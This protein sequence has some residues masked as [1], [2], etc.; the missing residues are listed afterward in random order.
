M[1][2]TKLR[3]LAPPTLNH[4][5][6]LAPVDEAIEWL[7][8]VN[9]RNAKTSQALA[10][11][12]AREG[13]WGWVSATAA[14]SKPGSFASF[15]RAA[16]DAAAKAVPAMTAALK[17]KPADW[18]PK[19]AGF[20]R[21]HGATSAAK[22]L[23][24]DYLARRARQRAEAARL[25]GESRALFRSGS[26]DDAHKVL[27]RLRDETRSP[28]RRSSPSNGFHGNRRSRRAQACFRLP[29]EEV[30]PYWRLSRR[31]Q[32]PGRKAPAGEEVAQTNHWKGG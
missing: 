3:L 29:R 20:L 10:T 16:E 9:G 7:D 24:T 23:V 4:M 21:I 11:K 15:H 8:T 28:T 31:P 1:G 17:G 5:F 27:E 32:M 6:M 13:E 22:P 26:R 19:W 14:T 12:W 2:W 18:V 30:L 25:F